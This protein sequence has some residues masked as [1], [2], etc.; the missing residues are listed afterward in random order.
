[1]PTSGNLL[2]PFHTKRLIHPLKR[3]EDLLPLH[4]QTYVLYNDVNAFSNTEVVFL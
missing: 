4:N 1:M 3:E 2:Y